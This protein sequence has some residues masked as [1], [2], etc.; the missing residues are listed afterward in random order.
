MHDR[1]KAEEYLEKGITVCKQY[2]SPVLIALYCHKAHLLYF[3]EKYNDTLKVCQEYFGMSKQIRSGLLTT[4]CE[5]HGYRASS[6]LHLSRDDEAVS[7]YI[8]FFSLLSQIKNGILRTK[9]SDMLVY[10]LSSDENISVALYEFLT[11]CL[12]TEDVLSAADMLMEIQADYRSF[13]T[14]HIH[15]ISNILARLIELC[16]DGFEK[17]ILSEKYRELCAL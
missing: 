17:N 14:D 4:D 10:Y 8:S 15:A 11:A 3:D 1:N 12:N 7:A 9:D 5:M 2:Q 16:S 6:L 13:R